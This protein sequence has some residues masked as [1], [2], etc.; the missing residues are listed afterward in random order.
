MDLA[1]IISIVLGIVII[2]GIPVGWQVRSILL[3]NKHLKESKGRIWCTFF[4][5]LTNGEENI[6]CRIE[7]KYKVIAPHNH[8]DANNRE[9]DYYF[10]VPIAEVDDKGQ[11]VVATAQAPNRRTYKIT[12]RDLWPPGERISR[13]VP[14]ERAYFVMG[15]PR[16]RNPFMDFLPVN[17]DK[18]IQAIVD[19]EI[20][21]ALSGIA[22]MQGESWELITESMQKVT[23]S[24]RINMWCTLGMLLIL[25]AAIGILIYVM[26]GI[27]S[28]KGALGV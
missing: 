26:T 9:I 15:D 14:I 24:V 10:L 22:R 19:A 28:L 1:V 20:G 25:M 6:L 18:L 3:R 21:K 8:F 11:L 5:P 16:P 4:D 27:N 17:I 13:Q 2:V 12:T 23:K 7:D